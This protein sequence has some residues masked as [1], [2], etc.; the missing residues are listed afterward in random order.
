MLIVRLYYKRDVLYCMVSTI[1]GYLESCYCNY[2]D[3][4]SL[5]SIDCS[6]EAHERNLFPWPWRCVSSPRSCLGVMSFAT[7]V[8]SGQ[9]LP[10]HRWLLSGARGSLWWHVVPLARLLCVQRHLALQL[11]PNGHPF[12][13][14]HSS[15]NPTSRGH[16]SC[17]QLVFQHVSAAIVKAMVQRSVCSI[18][19]IVFTW[20]LC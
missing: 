17:A 10:W 14:W 1:A 6:L 20:V 15:R 16:R 18:F 8:I 3:D 2:H 4:A 5:F 7:R 19:A 13:G 11:M 12:A 9:F